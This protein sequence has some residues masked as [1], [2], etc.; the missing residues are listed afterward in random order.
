MEAVKYAK[1]VE[2]NPTNTQEQTINQ[3]IGNCRFIF[4]F[5]IAENKRLYESLHPEKFEEDNANDK[6]ESVSKSNKEKIGYKANQKKVAQYK[7]LAKEQKTL[8]NKKSKTKTEPKKFKKSKHLVYNGKTPKEYLEFLNPKKSYTYISANDFEKWMNNEFL[9][10]NPNY[11]WIKLVSS[12][13]IKKS[14]TNAHSAFQDFFKNK[15]GYPKFKKKKRP[16][17]KMLFCKK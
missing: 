2:I 11:S 1:K 6:V 17:Y 15:K 5:F 8:G 12:K 4:N 16:R 14:L 10:K 3:T 7:K 13:A 9:P